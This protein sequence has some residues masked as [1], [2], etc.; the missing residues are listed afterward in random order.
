[1]TGTITERLDAELAS[2]RS[3]YDTLEAQLTSLQAPYDQAWARVTAHLADGTE[4]PVKD[5]K[6]CDKLDRQILVILASQSTLLS[7]ITLLSSPEELERRL[8]DRPAP[9]GTP[10]APAEAKLSALD[11]GVPDVYLGETGNFRPGMDARYKS[12]LIQAALGLPAP[13]ALMS[14]DPD[15]AV[16]RLDERGWTGFLDRKREKIGG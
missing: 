3:E 5:S 16:T 10:R 13:D 8:Q 4:P 9:S 7:R 6:T 12:D 1:M 15:D 11:R 2:A 14:F